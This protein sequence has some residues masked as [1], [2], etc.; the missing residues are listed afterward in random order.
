MRVAWSVLV[1]VAVVA[2]LA[3]GLQAEEKK[4]GKEVTLKGKITCGKCELKKDKACATVI[5]VTKDDKDTVYYF[6]KDSHKKYHKDICEEGKKGS[7]TGTVKKDSKTKKLIV[8]V[9]KLEYE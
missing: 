4:E 1:G 2:V 8:T 9:S 3:L 7:V 5:V 6:D